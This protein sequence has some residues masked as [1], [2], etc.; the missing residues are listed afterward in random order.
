MWSSA[1][2]VV[3]IQHLRFGATRRTANSN[4]NLRRRRT[5]MPKASRTGSGLS[6][7]P[8]VWALP[9]MRF[10]L[11]HLTL[12]KQKTLCLSKWIASSSVAWILD[13]RRSSRCRVP[14][15]DGSGTVTP[16]CGPHAPAL[17]A[18]FANRIPADHSLKKWGRRRLLYS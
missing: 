3:S 16:P 1:T 7:I 9:L 6:L 11:K 12:N 14:V 10:R 2:T 13:C 8:V 4:S 18:V 5:S 17:H 15:V